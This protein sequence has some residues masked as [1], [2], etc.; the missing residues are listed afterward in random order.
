MRTP[1]YD[2]SKQY[3]M[4]THPHGMLCCGVFNGCARAEPEFKFTGECSTL[5]PGLKF[6]LCFAPAVGW[7]PVHSELYGKHITDASAATVR[8]VLKS[9]YSAAICPGGFSES[10]YT[11]A[12]LDH[13]YAYLAG[14]VGFIKLAIEHGIDIAPMYTFGMNGMYQTSDYK[15]HERSV[16]SQSSGL[17]ALLPWGWM[18][19]SVPSSEEICTV[20]LDPFP[21]SRYTLD[22]IEE[23]SRD[24]A[25]YIEACFEAY[26]PCLPSHA[27]RR[28][29]FIGKDVTP[30]QVL[31]RQPSA[32]RL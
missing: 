1:T 32:S 25:A 29:L 22:Q 7:F 5:L 18:G 26:K 21:S 13:D 24:Y 6:V 2:T 19:T 15:R 11:G 31:S 8:K 10:V 9:G 28:L 20:Q 4:T 14:R 30:E 17:P 16:W 23:C 12:D 27:H 3:L